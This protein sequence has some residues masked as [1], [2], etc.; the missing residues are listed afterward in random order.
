M[1]VFNTKIRL[2]TFGSILQLMANI[3]SDISYLVQG[4]WIP[5]NIFR[6]CP[7]SAMKI[8]LL[9]SIWPADT[10]VYYVFFIYALHVK[11]SIFA[12]FLLWKRIM[13]AHILEF[14]PGVQL[15]ISTWLHVTFRYY[16]LRRNRYFPGSYQNCTLLA[17]VIS[18]K[19]YSKCYPKH[20]ITDK[21]FISIKKPIHITVISFL[22]QN[23]RF[24][25][26]E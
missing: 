21:I 5:L 2:N 26:S 6:N 12:V 1:Y 10:M 9:D 13:E 11:L 22:C 23:G 3:Y 8:Y 20:I 7:W 25:V 19:P 16:G 18:N 14:Y 15:N 17:T 4:T 24:D